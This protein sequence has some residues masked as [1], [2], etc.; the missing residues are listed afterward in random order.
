MK[1]L[2][3]PPALAAG[4]SPMKRL[5]LTCLA[6]LT[7]ACLATVARA[8]IE[9]ETQAV[10]QDKLLRRA[11]LGVE[12]VR[13]GSKPDEAREVFAREASTPLVPA[14]NLKIVTTS[15]ALDR[16]G[17]DFKFRTMLLRHGDDL[18]V[19]GDGDPTFGDSELLKKSGWTVTTVYESWAAR[20]QKL[21]VT[22]VGNVIVDDGIFDENFFNPHWPP[23]QWNYKYMA[24][25]GGLNLNANLLDILVQPGAVGERVGVTLEPPTRYV[26]IQNTC[27]TG[28]QNAVSP[29]RREGTNIIDLKGQTPARGVAHISATI[30]DPPMYAGT[31]LS[32]TLAAAGIKVTGGVKR[33]RTARAELAKGRISASGATA[34]PSAGATPAG[35][36][37]V[38]IH[39]T[40][41]LTAIARA[42]KDSVNLYAESLCKRLGAEVSHGSGSWENGTAAVGEFLK[43][44]GVP[45]E[46]FKLDDGSGLSRQNVVSPRALVRVLAYDYYGKNHQAFAD[47]LSVAGV[48]G[49]LEDR[50][51]G[52]DLRKRVF[53]KSGFIEGV[54]TIC[55][56]LHARDGQWYAFSIMVNG[57][58][59]L[60]NGEVKLLQERI[61]KAVDAEVATAS[62]RQ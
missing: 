56:Y 8:S 22:H 59:R 16:L 29:E 23:N 13:L 38:A 51:R 37:V 34:A 53:G 7:L 3:A 18:V 6:G 36:Q 20:L 46:E 25:V 55:G 62:A 52:S 2:F 12:I 40:P 10:A 43:R 24:Q 5:A 50:F 28:N 4:P 41:L 48:D 39:E 31:V 9:S 21:G 27:V 26:T 54:S 47:C 60:S 11:A 19:V 33:D 58:P 61:V 32:E 42:N 14:S 35:W 57:I 44:T 1:R 15:A 45:A 49:T 30:H 17:P